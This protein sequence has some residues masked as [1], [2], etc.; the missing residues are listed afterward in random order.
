VIGK[1][2]ERAGITYVG[3]FDLIVRWFIYLVAI[4]AA[5]D[6]LKIPVLSAFMNTVV[7]YLPSFIAGVLILIFGFII[8]DF[9]GDAEG[10]VEY[11][12]LISSGLK[13]FLYFVVIIIGLSVMKVDVSILRIFASALAWG[14]ALG[15]GAAVGIAFGLGFEDVVSRKGCGVD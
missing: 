4:L 10:K 7:Q 13:L 15:I 6:I 9:I 14:L 11:S 2:I 12:G 3:F 8:A 1:A 5:V